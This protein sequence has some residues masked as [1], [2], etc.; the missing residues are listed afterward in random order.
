MPLKTLEYPNPKLRRIAAPVESLDQ[1]KDL[2]VTMQEYLETP[3]DCCTGAYITASS[4]GVPLRVIVRRTLNFESDAIYINPVVR[5]KPDS[6][7]YSSVELC[8]NFGCITGIVQR[9]TLIV[10][11]Y[12][13]KDWV[14]KTRS[15]DGRTAIRIQHCMDHLMGVLFIDKCDSARQTISN[16]TREG[17]W[18]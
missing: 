18:Y 16:L 14:Q 9:H 1:V 15:F 3:S 17:H 13:D 2:I 12:L 7:M 5:I 11:R 10:M 4:F 8:S 6:E